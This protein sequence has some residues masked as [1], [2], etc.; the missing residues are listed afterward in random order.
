MGYSDF[1]NAGGSGGA[2]SAFTV[3]MPCENII[4]YPYL[5]SQL[6]EIMGPYI[7]HRQTRKCLTLD[8]SNAHMPVWL[9]PC[10]ATGSTLFQSWSWA[11]STSSTPGILTP[12]DYST[13]GCLLSAN[14]IRAGGTVEQSWQWHLANGASYP[15][16]AF[17][18]SCATNTATG[19][20]AQWTARCQQPPAGITDAN[21]SPGLWSG[22]PQQI[23]SSASGGCL[24]VKTSWNN[25]GQSAAQ[26]VVADCVA[27][28]TSQQW[29]YTRNQQLLNIGS[30]KCLDGR[31]GSLTDA[32]G[33]FQYLPWVYQCG[34]YCG[35]AG[36]GALNSE[37]RRLER[38]FLE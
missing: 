28:D 38:L 10:Q 2:W 18:A 34:G 20:V 19:T 35:N 21:R 11:S 33:V 31:G 12:T 22:V 37:L 1:V 9:R 5:G 8:T 15:G 6:W 16:V 32:T 29:L 7:V 24:T 25:C 23:I 36:C 13:P 14:N 17:A 27:G 4:D 26:V 3:M 30:A